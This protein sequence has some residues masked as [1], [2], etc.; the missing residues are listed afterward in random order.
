MGLTIAGAD[1]R[2]IK[3][4]KPWVSPSVLRH[5][6]L[7]AALGHCKQDSRWAKQWVKN[8]M[9]LEFGVFEPAIAR[10]WE[11]LEISPD[12]TWEEVKAAYTEKAEHLEDSDAIE[13][14]NFALFDAKGTVAA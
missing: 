7:S 11:V 9:M 6:R 3:F 2:Q 1:V 12:S 13:W 10:W 8:H 5:S 14:L 4:W